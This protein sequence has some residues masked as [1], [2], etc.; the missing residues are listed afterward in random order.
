MDIRNK[1]SLPRIIVATFVSLCSI[2]GCA[3]A[4]G[5]SA[6]TTP[7][8]ISLYE[9]TT[10]SNK[11]DGKVVEVS[12]FLCLR[13]D[14][15]LF[16]SYR[17]CDELNP[18]L[19][20]SLHISSEMQI[21]RELFGDGGYGVVV[22][23][24]HAASTG[25]VSIDSALSPSSIKVESIK[26]DSS[27]FQWSFKVLKPLNT[28]DAGFS[29]VTKISKSLISVVSDSDIERLGQLFVSPGNEKAKMYVADLKNQSSRIGWVFF[30]APN[31]L[32]AFLANPKGGDTKIEEYATDQSDA[33]LACISKGGNMPSAMPSIGYVLKGG[34]KF[35]FTVIHGNELLA[36]DF[37]YK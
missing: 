24:Y 20:V 35:C 7:S 4:S 30:G 8:K 23:L 5:P 32:H 10:D 18:A 2:S 21:K 16:F 19:G 29:D 27:P 36:S 12:G 14:P 25:E 31:S 28:Q 11:Y 22:G 9:L 3:S 34:S 17:E 26:P 15:G 6:T 37:L 1:F 33:V 13:E